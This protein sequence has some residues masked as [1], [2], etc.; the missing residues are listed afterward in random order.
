MAD[1]IL[2]PD[3]GLNEHGFCAKAV[4]FGLKGLPFRLPATRNDKAGPFF[5]KCNGRGPTD[6]GQGTRN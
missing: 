5:R 2:V 1:L 4:Q 6:P 3:V